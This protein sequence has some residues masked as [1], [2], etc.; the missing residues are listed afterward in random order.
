MLILDA[1]EKQRIL[2]PCHPDPTSGHLGTKR[3]IKR[4]IERFT[5]KGLNK[6]VFQL[7]LIAI[8]QTRLLTCL[9]IEY[10]M[11]R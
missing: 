9:N 2:H 3:T 7:V 1:C 5:W 4:I 11:Y 6:D 8:S 10:S